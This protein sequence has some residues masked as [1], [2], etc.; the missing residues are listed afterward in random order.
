MNVLVQG[1]V[2][3]SLSVLCMYNTENQ[4]CSNGAPSVYIDWCPLTVFIRL[5][6]VSCPSTLSALILSIARTTSIHILVFLFFCS[7]N[8]KFVFCLKLISY[9][10]FLTRNLFNCQVTINLVSKWIQVWFYLKNKRYYWTE[11]L[12]QIYICWN[13]S[14]AVCKEMMR[15]FFRFFRK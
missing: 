12:E 1:T 3:S 14:N 8:L 6:C 10:F 4:Q 15:R 9:Q 2:V 5:W 13:V 7:R 11:F